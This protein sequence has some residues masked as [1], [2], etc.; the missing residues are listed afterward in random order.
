MADIVI[1][2]N[3]ASLKSS[4]YQNGYIEDFIFHNIPN[5][6]KF[7]QIKGVFIFGCNIK[8][9]ILI[10][11]NYSIQTVP[12]TANLSHLGK[13]NI[14]IGKIPMQE[15]VNMQTDMQYLCNY[16]IKDMQKYQPNVMQIGR[17]ILEIG[18]YDIDNNEIKAFQVKTNIIQ[19]IKFKNIVKIHCGLIENDNPLLFSK[20]SDFSGGTYVRNEV[21]FIVYDGYCERNFKNKEFVI[22][23][24]KE[25]NIL[26]DADE[27]GI[28][29]RKSGR[30]S[31]LIECVENKSGN[32][33]TATHWKFIYYDGFIQ[34]YLS[35][36]NMNEWIAAGGGQNIEQTDVQ[37]FYVNSKT[38]LILK[39]YKTYSN[40]YTKFLNI[41]KG[42]YIK[43]YDKD[44]NLKKVKQS[45]DGIVEI[46]M[47][48]PIYQGYFT[49]CNEK[50]TVIYTSENLNI[51]LGDIFD[52]LQYELEVW[53]GKNIVERYSTIHIDRY[54][55][56]ITVKNI[57]NKT[58]N[59]IYVNVLKNKDNIDNIELS[60]DDNIYSNK[61]IIP[62]LEVNQIANIY[63][64]ITS[65]KTTSNYGKKHF[66]IEFT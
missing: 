58:Y 47:P 48:S 25:P 30:R 64:Q 4:V 35:Y 61:V 40:P 20:I 33:K 56:I 65:N 32:Q 10:T 41:P 21:S 27:Y 6:I 53:Y 62:T 36:D 13:L 16:E 51:Y 28:Y 43:I 50:E 44:N 39:D 18:F 37:G 17:I 46:Y 57:S 26:K 8:N 66:S 23:I 54:K 11:N 38:P 1:D 7:F 19:D 52:D 9:E 3:D 24:E 60:L 12:P 15:I 5:E 29:T 45:S 31:G 14:Q 55:E 2:Y 22:I 34:T 63:I 49:I 59:N 42:Y